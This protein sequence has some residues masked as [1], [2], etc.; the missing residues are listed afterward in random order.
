M[1]KQERKDRFFFI[2]E[3][4]NSVL[5][6]MMDSM[7]M[8]DKI[9]IAIILIFPTVITG[10][11]SAFEKPDLGNISISMAV[12]SWLGMNIFWMLDMV[13]LSKMFMIAGVFLVISSIIFS[14]NI[15]ILL[16]FKRFRR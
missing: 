6:F 15:R 4:T 7:W 10:L 11:V 12:N 13:S 3:A 8:M 5:W 16:R 9:N 2:L 14:R 1:K